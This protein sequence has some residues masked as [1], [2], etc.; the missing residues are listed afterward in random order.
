MNVPKRK[1]SETLLEFGEPV[2]GLLE[3]PTVEEFR[4]A[5]SIVIVVWNAH[6]LLMAADDRSVYLE[7]LAEY[8]QQVAEQGAPAIVLARFDA[9]DASRVTDYADDARCVGEWDLIPDGV[10]G[11]KFR[12]D[13][14]LPGSQGPK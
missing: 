12:C 9:L 4:A 2:L 8:R 13:T 11:F 1:I 3:E 5:L 14:R 6:G 10:G 7:K